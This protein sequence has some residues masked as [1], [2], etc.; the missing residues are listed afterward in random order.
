MRKEAPPKQRKPK[1]ADSLLK[2]SKK[3][4]TEL[5]EQE[6]DKVTGGGKHLAGVKYE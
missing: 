2:T 1:Q 3:K 4:D 5:T 6:L